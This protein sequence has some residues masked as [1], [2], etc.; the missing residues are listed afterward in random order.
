VRHHELTGK[1]TKGLSGPIAGAGGET[2]GAVANAL[3]KARRGLPAGARTLS[4]VVQECW[5]G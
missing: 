3:Q 5:K 2:W 1:W 4:Q